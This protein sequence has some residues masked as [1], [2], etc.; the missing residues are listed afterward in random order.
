MLNAYNDEIRECL[1]VTKIIMYD[2]FF[3]AWCII[4]TIMKFIIILI[5][6]ELEYTFYLNVL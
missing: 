4:L 6:L 3:R 1:A 5:T 2:R